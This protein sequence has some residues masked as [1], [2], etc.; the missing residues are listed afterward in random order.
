MII[1]P[2][3]IV[4]A[5]NNRSSIALSWYAIVTLV[6]NC[7]SIVLRIVSQCIAGHEFKLSSIAQR[8]SI[9]LIYRFKA[10]LH[11]VYCAITIFAHKNLH[12]PLIRTY[13]LI[14]C[15]VVRLYYMIVMPCLYIK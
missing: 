1:V 11:E 9:Y 2:L 7:G 12:I 8:P 5:H 6:Q 4:I 14:Y 13:L 3:E 15:Y 10:G